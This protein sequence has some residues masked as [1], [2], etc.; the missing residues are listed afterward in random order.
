[1]AEC[2]GVRYSIDS[3]GRVE[4]KTEDQKA[5]RAG[6]IKVLRRHQNYFP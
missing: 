4:V 2:G 5:E 3:M 6:R 1:M